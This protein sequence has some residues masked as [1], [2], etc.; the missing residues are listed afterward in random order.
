LEGLA[1]HHESK[2]VRSA[3]EREIGVRRDLVAESQ[4]QFGP[5][6]KMNAL[7]PIGMPEAQAVRFASS[8]AEE[9]HDELVRELP[10]GSKK[11]PQLGQIGVARVGEHMGVGFSGK[12]SEMEYTHAV[13]GR[14]LQLQQHYETMGLTGGWSSRLA[15]VQVTDIFA[16]GDGNI[17]AAKRA[18]HVAHSLASGPTYLGPTPARSAIPPP[19]SLVEMM[20]P[21]MSGRGTLLSD[22]SALRTRQSRD[23]PEPVAHP[24]TIGGRPRSASVDSMANS[25]PT[26]MGEH[27]QHM[28]KRH[29]HSL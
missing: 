7:G 26:C 21:A 4:L 17:C 8:L 6:T 3:A 24:T 13:E 27:E 9:A 16:E 19:E 23:V 14:M 18:A 15:P 12:K 29:D 22:Y 11:V 28:Q 2:L 1:L 20:N 5:K 25:C 10:R